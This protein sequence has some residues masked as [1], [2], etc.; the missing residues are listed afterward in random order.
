MNNL[1]QAAISA[2]EDTLQIGSPSKPFFNMGAIAG[3]SFEMG[4]G[5]RINSVM[6]SVSGAFA[7]AIPAPTAAPVAGG[8]AALPPLQIES[9]TINNDMDEQIFF[10][11][12]MA[13]LEQVQF[14]NGG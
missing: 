2:A 6:N 5:D 13:V 7:P 8:G 4:L 12:V 9:V 1:A 11:R 3:Q 10:A 14:Q